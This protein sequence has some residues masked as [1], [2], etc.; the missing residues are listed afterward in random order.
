MNA[1]TSC[2]DFE[3]LD[4]KLLAFVDL[5]IHELKTPVS[6]L[7]AY[8]QLLERQLLSAGSTD[9]LT[10]VTKMNMQL[11]KLIHLIADIRDGLSSGSD[12]MYCLPQI[13]KPLEVLNSCLTIAKETYKNLTITF[14]SDNSD[15]LLFFDNDRIEQVIYNLIA[16]AVKYAGTEE[17]L[18]LESLTA[19]DNFLLRVIDNG[20]G[21]PEHERLAIFKRFHRI[22]NHEK[23]AQP[24][25]GLGLYVC[26]QIIEKH[27]GQIGVDEADGGGASF[28]FSLPVY[29][30]D[31][32]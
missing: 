9:G 21:I 30:K 6:V 18:I 2:Q 5:T 11:D 3:N 25:F 20:P 4:P 13:Q 12:Q 19:G 17:P 24:G 14:R 7:K 1:K 22:A 27:G 15:P 8:I 23:Q 31:E 16:N 29:K 26:A 32:Q 10:T 28:W